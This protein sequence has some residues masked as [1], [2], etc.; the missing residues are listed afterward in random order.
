VL[1]SAVGPDR[2]SAI[3]AAMAAVGVTELVPEEQSLRFSRRV[4][5]PPHP[6]PGKG[7]AGLLVALVRCGAAIE[8]LAACYAR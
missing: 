3:E 2:E 8:A 1:G 6:A 5:P 4:D 7:E